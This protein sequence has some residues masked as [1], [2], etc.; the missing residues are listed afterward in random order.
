M[1]TGE[2]RYIKKEFDSN[3]IGATINQTGLINIVAENIG[4]DTLLFQIIDFVNLL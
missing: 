3:V 4:K 2:S 1:I